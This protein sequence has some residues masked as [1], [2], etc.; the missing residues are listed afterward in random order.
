LL[1]IRSGVRKPS[2]RSRMWALAED[3]VKAAA[4]LE[5]SR[6]GTRRALSFPLRLAGLCSALNQSLMELGAVVCTPARPD[7]GAC[8]LRRSCVARREGC[9][10]SLPRSGAQE[11]ITPRTELVLVLEHEGKFLVHQ[12]PAGVVNAHLWEFPT[13]EVA[14]G[15]LARVVKGEA[16]RWQVEGG[17]LQRLCQ[18]RHSITRYRITLHAFRGHVTE[19]SL[20][21]SMRARREPEPGAAALGRAPFVGSGK[22]EGGS[23]PRAATRAWSIARRHGVS[24]GRWLTIRRLKALP[25][26]AAHR[27][28]VQ[29]LL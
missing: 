20:R 7:C 22:G 5:R 21:S 6:Q 29:H 24:P 4:R 28:I 12:R 25:L 19:A 23:L 9:Q 18:I 1:G 17:Q 14:P 2:T 16:A 3:L 26:A 13:M 15:E 10:E 11:R 8:P 27:K